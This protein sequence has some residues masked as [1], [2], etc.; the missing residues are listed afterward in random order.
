MIIDT[1]PAWY[2]FRLCGCRLLTSCAE[3]FCEMGTT[4]SPLRAAEPRPAPLPCLRGFSP[5]QADGGV[6]IYFASCFGCSFLLRKI[7]RFLG[8]SGAAAGVAS[9]FGSA[10]DFT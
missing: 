4:F 3:P 6:A 10:A 5:V 7:R 2:V 9:A 8:S 1:I